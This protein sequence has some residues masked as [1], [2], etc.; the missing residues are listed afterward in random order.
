MSIIN[1][2][3]T[4]LE[5][6]RTRQSGPSVDLSCF[7]TEKP[8]HPVYHTPQFWVFV[9]VLAVISLSAFVNLN[10]PF[11]SRI[12][13]T[14]PTVEPAL[15]AQTE[16][17]EPQRPAP[18]SSTAN[19][20]PAEFA[21]A[22]EPVAAVTEIATA[23][24]T[25]QKVTPVEALSETVTPGATSEIAGP[26]P[27]TNL[28]IAAKPMPLLPEMSR[29]KLDGGEPRGEMV[30]KSRPLT[31]AQRDEKAFREAQSLIRRGL[32]LEAE[33]DLRQ[34]LE[35]SP[36]STRSAQ[37]LGSLL[38][39]QERHAALRSLHG[40]LALRGADSFELQAL[41]GRSLL[42][43][44]HPA[45]AVELLS[46]RLPDVF[47]QPGYHEIL[48]LAAQRAEDYRLSAATYQRLIRTDHRRADWWLG[49]AIALDQQQLDGAAGQAYQ[50]AMQYPGLSAAM[51]GYARDRLQALVQASAAALEQG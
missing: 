35:R 38:L 23:R 37:L 36:G 3:L 44:G 8:R 5:Q 47:L 17:V 39:S 2:M 32:L 25:Y 16:P 22:V 51:L 7:L 40:N 1:N 43:S 46:R 12:E 28:A 50:R 49:L 41:V 14:A 33:Q 30:K 27:A 19:A 48:A 10:E 45:K 6:R 20:P 13:E 11:S 15:K 31:A 21:V 29:P 4:D 9:V 34:Q 18:T 26:A 24:A 42:V